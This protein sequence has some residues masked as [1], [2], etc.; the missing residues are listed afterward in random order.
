MAAFRLHC[1][2]IHFQAALWKA[3]DKSLPSDMDPLQYGWE[4]MDQNFDQF[5]PCQGSYM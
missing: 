4:M 1:Q 5:L 3:A 2:H